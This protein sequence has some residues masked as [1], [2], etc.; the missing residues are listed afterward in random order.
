MRPIPAGPLQNRYFP[1][2]AFAALLILVGLLTRVGL[3]LHPGTAV[4]VTP[5]ALAHVFGMGMLFDLAAAAF[6]CAP[7]V[8]YLS[9]L[10]D[11][12]ARWRIHRIVF[13][14][15]FAAGI[16]V[17]CLVALSEWVFWDEFGTRFNFIAVDY[18][19]YTRE[20]LGNIWQSYPVGKL[21][22]AL[23]V[24]A[25][26]LTWLVR[27]PVLDALSA[28]ASWRQRAG[29][30]AAALLAPLAVYSAVSGS[31]KDL[32]ENVQQNELAGN[33][34]W[35]FF[36]AAY[37][38]ELDYERF[39][40][41][42]PAE[43][44][45]YA[46]ER[47]LD[48]REA[49]GDRGLLHKV[50][51]AG[52]ERRFNVVLISVESLGSEFIGALGNRQG[53]TPNLDALSK[54]SLFFTNLY[55]TGNRTVRG[56]EAL[57]LS[58]PPTPGESIVKRPHNEGLF[59]VGGVL[60]DKGYD[61]AFVYG[62]Y[63]YFD[64]MGYFFDHNGYRVVDRTA[65]AKPEIHHENIWGVA[66]EDLYGLTLR[67]ADRAARGNRPFFLHVM[68][69]SNHRPYTYPDG[70]I[71]IPSGSG[72]E[73]AVKYTDYAI[74]AFLREAR[75]RPWFRDT[76]FVI[77]AD[78]GASARGTED[79]P[80]ERYRIPLWIHAPGLVAP[81]RVDRLMSQIDI[82]PTLL[83]LLHARYDSKFF[84]ADVLAPGP[85][86]E[87]AFLATYQTLGYIRDGM[88]VTLA[89]R[90]AVHIR[91]LEPGGPRLPP[92]RERELEEEAIAFY[93]TASR[94]FRSGA[95]RLPPR[96]PDPV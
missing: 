79:I 21:L 71:D 95:Y 77:T 2:A 30:I 19:V 65:L 85:V 58:I 23:L 45:S 46:V 13:S 75:D 64:N 41:V 66:D 80:V 32:S 57:S 83:G 50:G 88:V 43:Q 56:L 25:L 39:Y 42:L 37:N 31:Q 26:G 7:L 54:E 11:R 3:W 47:L 48:A 91:P 53:L 72:R 89:P 92:E 38:S 63:S 93:Q 6:F 74:G 68:T 87:R 81:G 14:G 73:G 15:L 22:A 49:P 18:L 35:E 82:A 4:P 96:R 55:A 62:G 40:A 94:E 90:R 36:S 27:R 67:E 69:T 76:I 12:V 61:V 8:L 16:Y 33:G 17:L 5:T 78:H 28:P 70:R 84:G 51:A 60:A 10:P 20:V 44:A 24:P 9:L 59:S 1:A 34:S 29:G 86:P 52:A